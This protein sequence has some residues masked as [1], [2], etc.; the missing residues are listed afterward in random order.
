[1]QKKCEVDGCDKEV[2]SNGGR[3]GCRPF[4]LSA[5]YCRKHVRWIEQYGSTNPPKYAQGSLE[6]RFWKHV[7]KG[8]EDEC[9]EWTADTSRNGY[10]GIWDNERKKNSSAH[11]VSYEIHKGEIPAGLVVMHTCDNPKCVNP[12][13]LVLGTY[14]DNTQDMLQKGRRKAYRAFGENNPVSK[15]TLEQAKFIKANP[16][17]GHKQIADMFGVSPN[18]IRGVRIGRTW[19]DA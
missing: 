18:C 17:L 5:R 13:H 4:S 8:G 10:G 1:M 9:W 12:K 7:N 11:R 15:L 14:K 19:K 16:E 2:W 6:F 3:W